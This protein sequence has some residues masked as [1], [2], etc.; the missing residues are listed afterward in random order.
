MK[1][2]GP[3]ARRT[4][5]DRGAP[6]DRSGRLR[7]RSPRQADRYARIAEASREALERDGYRCQAV[8]LLPHDCH[9][10]IDPSHII[11]KGASPEQAD[12][13]ANILAI[14]R[15]AHDWIGGHPKEA[16]KL[17]LYGRWGDDLADLA[18]LRDRRRLR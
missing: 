15:T 2:T 17:G 18:R 13:P 9:G 1:R 12:D 8:G 3:P 4:P 14:C 7:S 6:L 11:S 5:L 16:R 10:R